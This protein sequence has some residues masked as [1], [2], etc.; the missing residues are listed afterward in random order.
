MLTDR[1]NGGSVLSQLH[2]AAVT[3]EPQDLF[4]LFEYFSLFQVIQ[5]L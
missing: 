3:A 5:Q 1:A 2:M 4:T